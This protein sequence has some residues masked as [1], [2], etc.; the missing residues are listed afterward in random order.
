MKF[1]KSPKYTKIKFS[2]QKQ[3]YGKKVLKLG[4]GLPLPQTKI[5]LHPLP[6]DQH[7]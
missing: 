5:S 3:L 6:S 2:P 7:R 4:L 1:Q